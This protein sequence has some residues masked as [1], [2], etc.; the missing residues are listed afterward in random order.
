MKLRMIALI[1]LSGAGAL[2]LSA[3]GGEEGDTIRTRRGRRPPASLVTGQGKAFGLPDLVN[4]QLRCA[5]GRGDRGG[6]RRPLPARPRRLSTRSGRTGRPQGHPHVP[7]R[8]LASYDSSRNG[9]Q[10]IRGYRV[11]NVLSVSVRKVDSAGKVI[12]DAVGAGG[13]NAIVQSISFTIEDTEALTQAAREDAMKEARAK[14]GQLANHAGVNVGKPISIIEGGAAIPYEVSP[15]AARAA[16]T[17]TP[18]EPGQLQVVVSVTVL[19]AIE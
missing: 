12:D 16:D 3:C 2:A 19:Y 10:V 9:I 17:A 1:V 6:A 13:N 11:T 5:G 14:A 15:I 8:R 7:V 18:I 4:L